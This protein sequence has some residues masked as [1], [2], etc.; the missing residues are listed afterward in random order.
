[1][2]VVVT[3]FGL[4]WRSAREESTALSLAMSA[5]NEISGTPAYMA[6]E[7]V[8]GGPVTPATDVYALGV[9]LYE[10]VTGTWPFVGETP[11]KM[12]TARLHEPPP[13]R[14]CMWR[15]SIRCGK[16]RFCGA[17]PAGPKTASPVPLTSLP[18][19]KAD[20]SSRHQ[21][22]AKA[23]A[24][25]G[26]LRGGCGADRPDD[27]RCRLCRVREVRRERAAGITSIAVLPLRN[28]SNDREQDY[29]SDGISEALINRL[30]QV[31][32]LKVVANS[33]SS[34]Y[35]GQDADPQDGG[36]RARCFGHPR[37]QGL[38]AGRQRLD[39]R[40]ADRWPRPDAGVGPAIPA[41]DS[42]PVSGVGG[43]LS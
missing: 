16:R 35:K 5:E 2:R 38:A 17:W 15:T 30:S 22:P 19:W 12:A 41:E 43:H 36:P 4:A 10:M 20:T 6:P 7:Q 11:L 40:R 42:R 3:D 18:R 39:Q 21:R 37:R 25:D 27:P 14:V 9:V 31:P 33:S 24:V 28:S 26:P 34:R 32:G 1:M 29:L 23:A 8:E 13:A